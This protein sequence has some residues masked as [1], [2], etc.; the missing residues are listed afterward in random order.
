M[1]ELDRASQEQLFIAAYW[2]QRTQ[3][4]LHVGYGVAKNLLIYQGVGLI[5]T[6]ASR[7]FG[8]FFE[9][10]VRS[11]HPLLRIVP[12]MVIG[13]IITMQTGRQGKLSGFY[14][15]DAQG[16]PTFYIGKIPPES[17]HGHIGISRKKFLNMSL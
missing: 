14:Q 9:S 3:D 2:P 8:M 17:I 4:E 11:F 7:V 15:L 12:L 10:K 16:N 5:F 1:K 6:L 13:T